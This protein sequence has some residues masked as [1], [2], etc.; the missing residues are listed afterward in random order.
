MKNRSILRKCA[1]IAA[2][3]VSAVLFLPEVLFAQGAVIGYAW[4]WEAEDSGDLS[5]YPTNDQLDKL[6][7]VMACEVY[8]NWDGSLTYSFPNYWN[9]GKNDWLVSLVSRA[10]AKGVKVS[11]EVGGMSRDTFSLATHPSKLQYFVNN[12]VSFVHLHDLDGVDIDWECPGLDSDWIPFPDENDRIAEWEQCI[13]LLTALKSALP[14]KRIS[15]ALSAYYPD[16]TDL[17]PNQ[18]VPAQ[19]WNTVDAV[20]LMTYDNDSSNW[21]PHSSATG[22]IDVIEY[23]ANWGADWEITYGVNLDKEKL[24]MGCAFYGHVYK[25]DGSFDWDIKNMLTYHPYPGRTPA[26]A[27]QVWQSRSTT[28]TTMDM[29]VCVFGN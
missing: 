2:F 13:H 15:I 21:Y 7:H 22:A 10:H 9:G 27:L 3:A 26:T 12:I 24:F 28:V 1:A 6:T 23:W 8:P 29:A 18:S 4:G 16:D 11:L 25:P 17:F 19:V 14:C 20:H 5:S